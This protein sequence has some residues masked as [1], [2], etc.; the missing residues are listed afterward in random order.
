MTFLLLF[1]IPLFGATCRMLQKGYLLHSSETEHSK[2]IYMMVTSSCAMFFFASMAGFHLSINLRTFVYAAVLALLSIASNVL[3]LNAMERM[4]VATV[5]V[6]SGA[7]AMVFPFL[8]GILF[9]NEK[10]SVFKVISFFL[11]L[12][13][14]A[15]PMFCK[16]QEEKGNWKGYLFC[17]CLFFQCGVSAM[18]G[19]IYAMAQNVAPNQVLCFWANV[20]MLPFVLFLIF[21]TERYSFIH[22]AKQ[23]K[24][25]AYLFAVLSIVVSNGSTL[26]ELFI[27]KSVNI[28]LY[29]LLKNP[30]LLIL[31]A[32]LSRICYREKITGETA[33]NIGLSIV[34]LILNGL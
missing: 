24:W 30:I 34:A 16:K 21:S 29:T 25:T 23:L 27:L 11:L 1:C 13:V 6:F 20:L 8:F 10:V 12:F 3:S 14:V 18:F 17:L 26:L 9:L 7:G 5:G 28:T 15:K 32:F 19:K 22:S 33:L 2:N 4:D 31:T